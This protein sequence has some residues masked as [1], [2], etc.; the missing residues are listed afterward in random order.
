MST[1]ALN[2]SITRRTPRHLDGR[3]NLQPWPLSERF[4]HRVKRAMS[5]VLKFVAVEHDSYRFPV[6][7]VV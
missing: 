3:P 1:A 6:Y 2:E 4:V 5:L 7:G